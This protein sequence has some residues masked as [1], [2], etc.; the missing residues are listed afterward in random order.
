M[1]IKFW[2]VIKR[3]SITQTV[4]DNNVTKHNGHLQSVHVTENG[5]NFCKQMKSKHTQA[6]YKINVWNTVLLWLCECDGTVMF[7]TYRQTPMRI[8]IHTSTATIQ[9][10]LIH[11]F[12]ML[13]MCV[14][15]AR[16]RIASKH[17]YNGR[18]TWAIAY[19]FI[20]NAYGR[21]RKWKCQQQLVLYFDIEKQQLNKMEREKSDC[22]RIFL[23]N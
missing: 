14:W 6:P 1:V 9:L 5:V 23:R 19:A 2:H 3:N 11:V 16:K 10:E 20:A 7:S 4:D 12:R 8:Q 18:V 13:F 22:W 21:D 15:L 17:A